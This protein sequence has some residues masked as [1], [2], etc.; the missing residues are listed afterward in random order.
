MKEI[1]TNEK[2]FI[3]FISN[4]K[5][6]MDYL[7]EIRDYKNFQNLSYESGEKKRLDLQKNKKIHFLLVSKVDEENEGENYKRILLQ[8]F[9]SNSL[10]ISGIFT[11]LSTFGITIS[12]GI[13]LS[14]INFS[15]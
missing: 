9:G 12:L 11:C 4:A 13:F 10:R 2:F 7:N 14:V 8:Y 6:F 5:K 3:Y 15:K 1:D